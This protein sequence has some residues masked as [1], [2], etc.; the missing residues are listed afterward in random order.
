MPSAL[1][2]RVFGGSEEAE[3][4]GAPAPG[5]PE[6]AG[7]SQEAEPAGN[8][9][10]V[11]D[12]EVIEA[13]ASQGELTSQVRAS[14]AKQYSRIRNRWQRYAAAKQLN[15]QLTMPIWVGDDGEV[16]NE[17][18]INFFK[19]Q[20]EDT[21][22]TANVHSTASAWAYGVI[23]EQRAARLKPRV[24]KGYVNRLPIITQLAEARNEKKKSAVR[25]DHTD[26]H[27]HLDSDISPAQMLHMMDAALKC[28]GGFSSELIA[29]QTRFALR[30]SFQTLMRSDSL[31]S[32]RFSMMFT[33]TFSGVGPAGGTALGMITNGGKANASGKLQYV[34]MLPHKNPM[35]CGI[36]A[37][38]IMFALRFLVLGEKFPD[39]LDHNEFFTLPT[40]RAHSAA[41]VPLSYK[42]CAEPLKLLFATAQVLCEKI[43]HQGRAQGQREL[44]DAQISQ[45][46][47][48]LLAHYDHSK[49]AESYLCSLQPLPLCA[50]AGMCAP[51]D[52]A[53]AHLM[54]KFAPAHVM[55]DVSEDLLFAFIPVL[56][57]MHDRVNAAIGECTKA[58]EMKEQR[59]YAARGVVRALFLIFKTT[60]QAVA[61]RPRDERGKIVPDAS[62]LY[63]AYRSTCAVMRLEIFGRADETQAG[64]SGASGSDAHELFARFARTVRAAEDAEM[65]SAA[66]TVDLS[67]PHKKAVHD[68]VAGV[69]DR[70]HGEY[71]DV[72]WRRHPSHPSRVRARVPP[73][74]PNPPPQ[75]MDVGVSRR[76]M[77]RRL[78]SRRLMSRRLGVVRARAHR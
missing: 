32:E 52:P 10:D 73:P 43:T 41:S 58:T 62:P 6:A 3:E 51:G 30:C 59:L 48:A 20:F 56:K 26:M 72:R 12:R 55:C 21:G 36:A 67:S 71:Q 15:D 65:H 18:I 33:R 34:G 2:E 77:S 17:R 37:K 57:V 24:E 1:W 44:H 47:I 45:E 9:E 46:V 11:V 8:S 40:L 54:R 4:A 53:E 5:A 14:S 38:G 22:Y 28:E 25:D 27:A 7:E 23:N 60:L 68:V 19:A 76:L 63:I 74:R 75:N 42:H 70:T 16:L 31:L 49:Q 78:M 50:A 13:M 66:Q 64:A 35:L 39:L 29:A 61:A 69:V